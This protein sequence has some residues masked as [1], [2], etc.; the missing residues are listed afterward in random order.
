[1]VSVPSAHSPAGSY[2]GTRGANHSSMKSDTL[3]AT[4]LQHIIADFPN[5]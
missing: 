4:I 2:L 5:R 1:V 3:A